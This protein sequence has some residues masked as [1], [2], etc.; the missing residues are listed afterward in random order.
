[1]AGLKGRTSSEKVRGSAGERIR[2]KAEDGVEKC[3]ASEHCSD[4]FV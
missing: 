1:M 3:T 4:S 2:M